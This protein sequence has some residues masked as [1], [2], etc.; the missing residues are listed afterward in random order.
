MNYTYT[1][2]KMQWMTVKKNFEWLQG[3]SSEFLFT[4][5]QA[6]DILRKYCRIF[7]QYDS[8]ML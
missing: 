7:P 1:I 5:T 8:L 4:G 2:D 6:G 3:K